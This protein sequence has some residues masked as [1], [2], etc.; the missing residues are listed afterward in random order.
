MLRES[1]HRPAP[2]RLSSCAL[3]QLGSKR[4]FVQLSSKRFAAGLVPMELRWRFLL[5][6]PVLRVESWRPGGMLLS[7][8]PSQ[9]ELF[10]LLSETVEAFLVLNQPASDIY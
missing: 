8:V 4:S 5:A 6:V 1:H 10:Y 9:V 3:I 7:S 2:K